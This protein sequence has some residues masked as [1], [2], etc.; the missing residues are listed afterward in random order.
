MP[1]HIYSVSDNAY[2]DRLRERHNHSFLI[3]GESGADKTVKT[4]RAIQ[5]FAVVAALGAKV[6]GDGAPALKGGGS[7]EDQIVA[8]NP[9]MEAFNNAKTTRNDNSSRFCKF[10]RIHFG[11]TGKLASCWRSHVSSYSSRPSVASTFS[12]RFVPAV[13]PTSTSSP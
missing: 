8:A 5:Y 13:A 3:T 11:L 2:N 7:L 1:P 12:I 4:K 6:G 10:I 9:A